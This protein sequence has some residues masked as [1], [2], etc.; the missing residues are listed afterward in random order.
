MWNRQ[1]AL[2]TMLYSLQNVRDGDLPFLAKLRR[3]FICG[4][5][6]KCFQTMTLAVLCVCVGPVVKLHSLC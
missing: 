1:G 2:T 6:Y 4:G 3:A 5:S